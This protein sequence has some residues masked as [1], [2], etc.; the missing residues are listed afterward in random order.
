MNIPLLSAF[1]FG[2]V[3]HY[4]LLV[5]HATVIIDIGEHYVRQSYRTRTG[6]VG[7]TGRQDLSVQ[8]MHDHG[9]KIHRRDLRWSHA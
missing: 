6:I 1:Y 8:V 7:P 9:R 4:R 5:Q 2:S 3:E